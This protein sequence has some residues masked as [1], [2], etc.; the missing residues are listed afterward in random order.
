MADGDGGGGSSTGVVAV[1]VIF[2]IVIALA[3][4]AWRG[5]ASTKSDKQDIFDRC[6][7]TGSGP[8]RSRTGFRC[9]TFPKRRPVCLS[10]DRNRFH[11][12]ARRRGALH[13]FAPRLR[14]SA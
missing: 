4:F 2:L 7:S 12:E 6:H 13:R 5:E 8:E 10:W 3:F 11:A 14:A 1:L 9:L